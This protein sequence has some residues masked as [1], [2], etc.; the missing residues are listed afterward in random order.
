MIIRG[1]E[2]SAGAPVYVIAELGVNHDGSLERALE[3]VDAAADAGADAVKVQVFDAR[4]LLSRAAG[5]ASYQ[6]DAGE[7]DPLEMLDRL[8]LGPDALESV[9]ERAHER[10]LAAI[11]TVFSLGLVGT[12]R[13]L[14]FDAFKTASPDVVNRPLLEQIG[15]DERPMIVSTGASTMR[16]VTRAMKWLNQAGKRPALLHCVSCYPT[17]ERMASLEGT[18]ALWRVFGDPVGYSDHTTSTSIGY[19]A[20]RHKACILEKHLTHNTEAQG[21]DHG[22]SLEPDQF[23]RYCEM[24]RTALKDDLGLGE[25]MLDPEALKHPLDCE[26]DVRRIAR[27]SVTTTRALRAG[28]TI[29]PDAITIKRPGTGISPRHFDELGGRTVARDIEADMPLAWEDLV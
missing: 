26:K 28:S 16:E 10:G 1:R 19:E 9:I 11:A 14:G 27:Q 15:R 22:A 24:A 17:P 29:E 18:L 2:V 5:L 4:M 23:A 7:G 20:V 3:L 8:Q 25:T 13:S 21:P 6:R 12:A